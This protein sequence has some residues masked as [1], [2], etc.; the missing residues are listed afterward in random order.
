MQINQIY[1]HLGHPTDLVLSWGRATDTSFKC[2][3]AFFHVELLDLTK[4]SLDDQN[5]E[6]PFIMAS[7]PFNL[8]PQHN[9]SPKKNH[10]LMIG[11]YENQ[12]VFP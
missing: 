12:L 4:T 9:P 1:K 7:Q 6:L 8:T 5:S 3:K 10:G 11:A 2:S